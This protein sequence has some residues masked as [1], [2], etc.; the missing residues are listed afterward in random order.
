MLDLD[1]HSVALLSSYLI[2][3]SGHWTLDSDYEL[4]PCNRV[5]WPLVVMT[6]FL[7][8]HLSLICHSFVNSLQISRSLPC[9][10]HLL[11]SSSTALVYT[12]AR[13]GT[14]QPPKSSPYRL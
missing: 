6:T 2:F 14:S 13:T 4:F 11:D 8:T 7:V 5:L 10:T 1:E 12:L 3:L 9:S